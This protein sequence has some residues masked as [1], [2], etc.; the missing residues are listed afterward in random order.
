MAEQRPLHLVLCFGGYKHYW[1]PAHP[2]VD[3]AELLNLSFMAEYLAPV[4]SAHAPGVRIDYSSGDLAL[5]LIDN[6]PPDA[7]D[8]YAESFR[9]LLRRFVERSGVPDN[10]DI[11]LFRPQEEEPYAS[12]GYR[13]RLF[14]RIEELTGPITASWS[15]LDESQLDTK[16]KRTRRSIMW[17]G[18][19]N[20]TDLDEIRQE[21]A[22][23]RSKIVNECYYAADFELRGDYFDGGNHIPVVQS[24]GLCD[25]NIGEWLTLASTKASTVDFWIG[26]GVLEEHAPSG[27]LI[28]KVV[29][30]TQCEAAAQR[31]KTFPGFEWAKDSSLLANLATVE[32]LC[33]G[34]H[35]G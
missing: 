12:N 11:R 34:P 13:D 17:D 22:L 14:A 9:A 30:R 20:M 5:K 15:S 1:N 18:D 19:E 2:L 27:R 28:D 26:R 33:S 29:S 32:V 24:W 23:R 8:R 3:F 6:Y 25:E 10:L 21:A 4:L 31:L 35:S 16:L 7:S